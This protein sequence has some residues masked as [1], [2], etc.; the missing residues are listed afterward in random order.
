MDTLWLKIKF[1]I[2]SLLLGICRMFENLHWT[3]WVSFILGIGV[4]IALF[5]CWLVGID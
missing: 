5:V 1:V 3:E 4:W 2:T